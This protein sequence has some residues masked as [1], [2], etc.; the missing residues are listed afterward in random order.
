MRRFMKIIPVI[1]VCLLLSSWAAAAD[2]LAE[3]DR[4]F[5][6]GGL[7]NLRQS[8]ALT[9]KAVEQNPGSFEA[10]RGSTTS[11]NTKRPVTSTAT[12]RPI[13]FFPSC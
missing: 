4:L 12:S 8:I 2:E 1:G 10:K 9:L 13:C 11:G 5:A 6:Q 3:A 7:E